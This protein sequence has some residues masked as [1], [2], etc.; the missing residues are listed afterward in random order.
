M[1]KFIIDLV[2]NYNWFELPYFNSQEE[3]NEYMGEEVPI[4]FNNSDDKIYDYINQW[5][6]N[7]KFSVI[8]DKVD[9]YDLEDMYVIREVVFTIDEKYY[10]LYYKESYENAN[11]LYAAPYEVYPVEK[12]VTK[13]Y[14]KER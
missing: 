12:T 8:Y 7:H 11:R 10:R 4:R 1:D 5:E 6:K 13:Y 2:I 3:L 9:S 14:A